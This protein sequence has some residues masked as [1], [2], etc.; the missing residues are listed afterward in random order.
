[1]RI[2]LGDLRVAVPEDLGEEEHIR[3]GLKE[4]A[5]EGVAER[6][7]S[8]R[9]SRATSRSQEQALRD[10][11]ASPAEL[12]RSDVALSRDARRTGTRHE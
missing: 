10:R 2:E 9:K 1:M 4:M 5:R 11:L 7:R 12:E 6:M 8:T 3:D